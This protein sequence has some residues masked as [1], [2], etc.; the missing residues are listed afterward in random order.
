MSHPLLGASQGEALK[1]LSDRM[2]GITSLAWHATITGQVVA[3]DN[4]Q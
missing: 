3:A 1:R 4:S 2:Y